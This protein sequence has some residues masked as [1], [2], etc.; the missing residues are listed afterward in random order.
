MVTDATDERAPTVAP[1]EGR[2][3]LQSAFAAEND[4]GI[5]LA[6][7]VR[8]FAVPIL[9]VWVTI[10]NGWPMA[11]FQLAF[12]VAFTAIGVAPLLLRRWGRHAP[13]Q[14]Y[15]FPFLDMF[16]LTLLLLLPN[17]LE[18]DRPPAAMT[19]RYR[20]EIYF[21][22]LMVTSVFTYSPRIVL[23]SGFSAALCWSVGTLIIYALPGSLGEP[24]PESLA[25]LDPLQRAVVL[26]DPHRVYLG[27]LVREVLVLIIAA[28]GLALFVNRV[29][30]LVAKHAD[31]ERQR[32]NLSRYFSANMVEELAQLDEP[33]GAT[34]QQN[35]AVLFADIV[36]FT[37]LSEKMPPEEVIALLRD[38]HS[39]LERAVFAHDGTLDKYL[40]DGVMATFGTPRVGPRD[41]SNALAC[42]FAMVEAIDRW[43]ER[44]RVAGQAAIGIGIGVHY[45]PVVLGD[46]G[47]DRRLEFAV[48]GDTVNTASRIEEL[49]RTAAVPLLVSDPLV[50]AVRR[51][52]VDE[53][54]VTAL[55]PYADR[56]LRG[57]SQSF[58]IWQTRLSVPAVPSAPNDPG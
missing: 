2:N 8:L 4:V 38:F 18:A 23:W 50:A 41:A 51:E 19:L 12:I 58:R 57:R 21:F 56:E 35:V 11:L 14:D 42:A 5:R 17:P 1:V 52:A 33:L 3:R 49:T 16:L 26:L 36:G 37:A 13:R 43:N 29:R 54:L 44:R 28:S 34:R 55:T 24:S 27:I 10:E 46:I 48:L 25:G 47:G 32:G 31:S 20:N 7:R 6:A 22:L 53:T 39:I 15:L 45:G 30:Q 40:G 9:A